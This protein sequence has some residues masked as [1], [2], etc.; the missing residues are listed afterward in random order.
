MLTIK[1]SGVKVKPMQGGS[2]PLTDVFTHKELFQKSISKELKGKNVYFISQLMSLDRTRFLRYKD[3]K[4]R[5]KIN[6]QGRV[7][8]WFK[9]IENKLVKEPLISKKVKNE[10]QLEYNLYNN[11]V[12]I[13]NVKTRNW[14][15]TFCE[16]V[17]MP[18]IGVAEKCVIINASSIQNDRYMVDNFIYEVLAQAKCKHH[19]GSN[20]KARNIKKVNGLL[21]YIYPKNG[22]MKNGLIDEIKMGSAFLI[23][24]PIDRY[25]NCSIG[26]NPFSNKAELI[27][28]ILNLMAYHK[29]QMLRIYGF[30]VKLVKVKAHSNSDNNNKIDKL[31][32][33]G[34][35][36]EILMIEDALLLHNGTICW[37]DMPIEHNSILMIKGIKDAQFIDKFIMLNRNR[38]RYQKRKPDLY[39]DSWKCNFCGI[40]EEMFDHFWKC[41]FSKKEIDKQQ[42][43][44]KVEKLDMWNIGYFYDFTFLMKN[45]VSHQLVDLLKFYKIEVCSESSQSGYSVIHL[46]FDWIQINP[47]DSSD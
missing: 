26:D 32:K 20:E 40:E 31:A 21:R 8:G 5:I 39:D 37:R 11:D 38:I 33:L 14:I 42:L 4:H 12:N 44:N 17:N 23:S 43:E 35:K 7:L 1:S 47:N 18:I 2:L 10:Y 22:F 19:G 46:K 41:E 16:Q 13:A 27:P 15:A 6:T 25:F 24:S 34:I 9:F 30:N 29:W 28:V 3:L 45:Q 36:K